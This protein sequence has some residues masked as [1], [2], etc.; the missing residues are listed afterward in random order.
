MKVTLD[1]LLV[2]DNPFIGVN[3]LSEERGREKALQLNTYRISKVIDVAFQSGA[4]GMF[5]SSHP[6]MLNVLKFMQQS[7]YQTPFSLY[8][9]IPDAQS[10]VRK[11]SQHGMVGLLQS[12]LQDLNTNSKI[13]AL[14]QIGLSAI[15]S[16]PQRIL[17]MYI[18]YEVSRV[19]GV[20]P[21]SAVLKAVFLHELMT[22]MISSFELSELARFFINTMVEKHHLMPGFVTRNFPKFL[23]FSKSQ[24]I[25][26]S[27]VLIATPINKVGFQVNPSLEAHERALKE[28]Q[29]VANIVAMNILASGYLSLEEA[30]EYILKF[31]QALTCAVGVSSEFHAKETFEHLSRKFASG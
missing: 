20:I 2:G 9:I 6:T 10:I 5:F 25:P 29:G 15:L 17:G 27:E 13:R 24:G 19:R 22:D 23:Q 3:H 14:A 16:D 26:L 28:V 18:D 21:K 31:D 1:K 7:N 4:R 12:M 11:A 8:M 30:V